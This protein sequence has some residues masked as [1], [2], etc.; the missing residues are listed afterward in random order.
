[1]YRVSHVIYTII[2]ISS[3]W[4]FNQPLP[5]SHTTSSSYRSPHSRWTHPDM[6]YGYHCSNERRPN[7]NHSRRHY[8]L[9]YFIM[10]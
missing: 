1:M 2:A 10:L 4:Y 8:C 3:A 7:N 5:V 6:A 9:Y